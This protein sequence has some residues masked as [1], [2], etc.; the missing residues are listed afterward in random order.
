MFIEHLQY[1]YC[2]GKGH[3]LWN[4]TPQFQ[5]LAFIQNLQLFIFLGRGEYYKV[6]LWRTIK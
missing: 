6:E 4:Q 1:A 2:H 5:T 3:N